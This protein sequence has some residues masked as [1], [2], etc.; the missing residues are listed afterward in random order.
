MDVVRFWRNVVDGNLG[1]PLTA[2]R[3]G[4]DYA[5]KSLP[6]KARTSHSATPMAPWERFGTTATPSAV[7]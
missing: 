7:S 6:L 2:K 5:I 1:V 3:A 4:E